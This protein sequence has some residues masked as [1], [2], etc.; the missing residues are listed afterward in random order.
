LQEEKKKEDRRRLADEEERRK[1]D[2]KRKKEGGTRTPSPEKV[3]QWD[4]TPT[5]GK[6]GWTLQVSKRGE[7]L[8]TLHLDVDTTYNFGREAVRKFNKNFF[9]TFSRTTFDWITKV[10]VKSTR[11]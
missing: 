4:K 6:G 2:K 1:K 11:K 8:A 9:N 10:A 7:K 5:G 3:T